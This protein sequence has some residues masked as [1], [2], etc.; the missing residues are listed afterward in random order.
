YADD[1]WWSFVEL[2]KDIYAKNMSGMI[3]YI[4]THAQKYSNKIDRV[5]ELNY[6]LQIISEGFTLTQKVSELVAFLRNNNIIFKYIEPV[7]VTTDHEQNYLEVCGKKFILTW[8]L[9][10]LVIAI[11]RELSKYGERTANGVK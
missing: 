8:D 6:L 7:C 5:N 3:G 1:L 2:R 4:K 11:H 10:Q 9:C